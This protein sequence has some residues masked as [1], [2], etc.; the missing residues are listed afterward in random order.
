[1]EALLLRLSRQFVG[2]ER[3]AHYVKQ[4]VGCCVSIRNYPKRSYSGGRLLRQSSVS[5]SF[6]NVSE[7]P[8]TQRTDQ[9]KFPPWRS[10]QEEFPKPRRVYAGS[11][12]VET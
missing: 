9:Q 4:F 12:L 10:K 2:G 5:H 7:M 8:T 11:A 1:M 6:C 3:R